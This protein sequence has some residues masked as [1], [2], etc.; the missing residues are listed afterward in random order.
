MIPSAKGAVKEPRAASRAEAAPSCRWTRHLRRT[1]WSRTIRTPTGRSCSRP[2]GGELATDDRDV[3]KS[4]GD[5]INVKVETLEHRGCPRGERLR[6]RAPTSME[7]RSASSIDEHYVTRSL[8]P[9][10]S[11]FMSGLRQAVALG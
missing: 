11:A 2:H 6:D 7:M 10:A 9:A 1:R 3:S 4:G 5:R 8:L